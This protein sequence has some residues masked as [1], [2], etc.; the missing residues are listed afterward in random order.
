MSQVLATGQRVMAQ[1]EDSLPAGLLNSPW[2][3]IGELPADQAGGGRGYALAGEGATVAEPGTSRIAVHMVAANYFYREQT[4]DYLITQR[5]ESHT[6]ALDFRRG[7]KA[8]RGPR[9]ELGAQ[10]QL[11]HRNDGFL[12]G[13]ISGFES[14]SL[15]ISGVESAKNQLRTT[16]ALPLGA[17]VT[18]NGR[19]V[20][21]APGGTSGIGDFSVVA[22]ALLLDASPR[23]RGTRL[24]ARVGLNVAG[25]SQFA[26]GHFVGVGVGL[27]KKVLSWAAVHGDVRA[28]VALDRMSSWNLPL[29]RT[30]VGF[31]IGPE[32][33]LS[34]GS[35]L[36]MQLDGNTSP[37]LPTGLSRSTRAT[38]A[39]PSAS[40][41]AS[42]LSCRSSTCAR[43]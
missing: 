43:T 3:P 21:A 6:L 34:R 35:S 26:E 19:P 8:A 11:S 38:A 33:R 22:K 37:Y 15:S 41:T 9:F 27:D 7:F 36:T 42:D 23:S 13:F 25:T 40:V 24:A 32:L 1:E 5:Y 20:Y 10:L 4:S 28:T 18:R 39:S 29:K 2:E 31:S 17:F 12:N 16:G 30:T 14:L